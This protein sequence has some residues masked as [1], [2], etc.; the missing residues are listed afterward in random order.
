MRLS[1]FRSI[2]VFTAMAIAALSQTAAS[3]TRDQRAIREAGDKWQRDIGADN[4][5]AI[6]ALH[7]PDAVLM[8]S[9]APLV[10]GSQAVRATYAEMVKVPGL[11]LHWIPT[12]I[13]VTS[14]TTATEYGTYAESFDSPGGKIRDA[15]NYVV[16]WRKIDG[17]WRIALDA[18]ST[19][20]PLPAQLPADQSDMVSRAGSALT[21]SDFAPPGFPPG[22]KI[23][24]L[25]GDPFSP[26]QFVLR[27]KLPDGY[28]IPLHWH[29]TGEYVTVISG[30]FL[31][32]MGNSLDTST[33]RAFNPGDFV[34]IPPRQ[35][36][37]A[38]ARGETV[39]QITGNGPFQLNLG[40]PK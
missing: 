14:P 24:V 28:Q 3:Q 38:R 6:V 34:Y 25:H 33:S 37:F 10:K 26:G 15:G 35:P 19:T 13:D 8:F 21:W 31:F 11:L 16:L 20:T 27:L 12:K 32:G 23:S 9:N 40:V 2:A 1:T 5:E 17:K 22:G 4:V 39:V 18:P 36:H 7:T 30:V 29:P